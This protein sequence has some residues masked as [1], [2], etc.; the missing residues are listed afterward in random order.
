[1]IMQILNLTN[2]SNKK[3]LNCFLVVKKKKQGTK[4]KKRII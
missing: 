2:I 1:M 4:T 3:I